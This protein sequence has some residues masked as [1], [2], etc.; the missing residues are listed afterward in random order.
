MP[1]KILCTMCTMKNKIEYGDGIH[2]CA[3]VS[4][5]NRTF[6]MLCSFGKTQ[7]INSVLIDSHLTQISFCD[8][9]GSSEFSKCTKVVE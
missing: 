7:N 6:I 2:L 3:Y 1:G 8:L 4:N 5:I 9:G